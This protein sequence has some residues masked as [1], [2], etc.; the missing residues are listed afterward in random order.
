MKKITTIILTLIMILSSLFI[1]GACSKPEA[2]EQQNSFFKGT[3][4][5]EVST[6]E[7]F[8]LKDGVSSYKIVIPKNFSSNENLASQEIL[9]LFKE[10]TGFV[11]PIVTDENLSFDNNSQYISVGNTSLKDTAG[12]TENVET[13]KINGF[14]IKTVG[15]SVFIVGGKEMGV[16]YGAYEFLYQILNFEQFFDDCYSLDTMVREIPLMNYNFKELPDIKRLV[17]NVGAIIADPVA[18]RRMRMY[19]TPMNLY[20]WDGG[21]FT[22]TSF[23]IIPPKTYKDEHSGWFSDDGSQ[24]CYTAH[25]DPDEYDLMIETY[26]EHLKQVIIDN[27]GKYVYKFADQDV[28][29]RCQCASCSIDYEKYKCAAGSKI[30]F[31]NIVMDKLNDWLANDG[32]EYY[33]PDL[34][35]RF[36]AYNL[37]ETA[38]VNYDEATDTYTPIDEKMMLSPG[39]GVEIAPVFANYARSYF[40][41][42][43]LNYYNNMR[44]W[45]ALFKDD[46]HIG[47]WTYCFN[48]NHYMYFFN[49]FDTMQEHYQVYA[50]FGA[51]S[52]YDQSL[53]T[54]YDGISAWYTLKT[55][56]Q[57]KLAWD[58]NLNINELTQRFFDNYYG[59]A[60]D[61]MM[62]FYKSQRA[63]N[64]YQQEELGY[65]D[66]N[67]NIKFVA[68]KRE[69]WPRNILESWREIIGDALDEIESLKVKNAKKYDLIYKHIVA[70][71]IAVD[72]ILLE[73]Y[74]NQLSNKYDEY[75]N[76]FIAEVTL[77]NMSHHG[78]GKSISSFINS[79]N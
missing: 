18:A 39:L 78:A 56:L 45:E 17:A 9:T 77:N 27:P 8:L 11:L 75:K 48:D 40:D 44:A 37:F 76:D 41:D 28:V 20:I 7:H 68:N 16:V 34:I 58:T 43:N 54:N 61:I 57:S 73:L 72:F 29:T 67:Y 47:Y 38:P 79:L 66:A 24:L 74:S 42:S 19:Y 4:V 30:I 32:K 55:Y 51:E 21:D 46:V 31:S 22:D 2:E 1:S 23:K 26:V 53:G 70:E 14:A 65:G 49:T 3:H 25:G 15:K 64:I 5:K 35:F 52:L 10:A 6:T 62:K 12:I 63:F 33:N 60:S 69:Y 71:R 36:N 59:E 13:L 50:S